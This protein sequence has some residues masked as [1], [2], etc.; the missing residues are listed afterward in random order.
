MLYLQTVKFKRFHQYTLR[1]S[2]FRDLGCVGMS[3]IEDYNRLFSARKGTLW[4][5]NR[6]SPVL[7]EIRGCQLFHSQKTHTQPFHLRLYRSTSVEDSRFSI[8][9]GFVYLLDLFGILKRSPTPKLGD[10][11]PNVFG[12]LWLK[13][14]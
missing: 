14:F 11:L 3:S 5:S 10:R 1:W 2:S 9:A 13:S 8:N 7:I 12:K 4:K 6:M